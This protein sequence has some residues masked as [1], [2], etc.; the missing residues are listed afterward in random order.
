M[1][2]GKVTNPFSNRYIVSAALVRYKIRYS[3]NELPLQ[4]YLLFI[5]WI[6][7]HRQVLRLRVGKVVTVHDMKACGEFD[8]VCTVH[9]P[10]ICTRVVP[11]V[12]SNNFL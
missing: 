12:M 11:K 8:V 9:Y 5:V 6:T 3:A 4:Y 7:Y 2:F 10:T 1:F